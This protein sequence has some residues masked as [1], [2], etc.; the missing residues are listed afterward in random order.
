[1]SGSAVHKVFS[2]KLKDANKNHKAGDEF[3]LT[4][5]RHSDTRWTSQFE[6]CRAA[7]SSMGFI[8]EALEQFYSIDERNAERRIVADRL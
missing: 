5:K 8:V 3:K 1:M 4:L 6:S 2:E 7:H